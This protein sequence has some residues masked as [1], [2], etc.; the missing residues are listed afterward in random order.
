[1]QTICECGHKIEYERSDILNAHYVCCGD[2]T[3]SEDVAKLMGGFRADLVITDPP[4][5][6]N[7][8]GQGKKT[9]NKIENDN[10][11]RESFRA[12][13]LATFNCYKEAAKV[14]AP[15]YWQHLIATKKP[16]KF[17]R[18]FM[19]AIQVVHRGISRMQWN[20]LASI[21]EIRSSG[22][23]PS[24]AWAGVITDGNMSR[25]FMPLLRTRSTNFMEIV[26]NIRY[27][28]RNGILIKS[29]KTLKNIAKKWIK[30][31]RQFGK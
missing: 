20:P 22:I 23:K 31:V 18:L 16:R 6:V 14:S 11:S 21:S 9:S 27:W 7:Y 4:Y 26:H 3:K 29:S 30:E 24:Q 8:S 25:F 2:S 5:N 13:L 19:C 28:M 10:M 12:F 17:P 15:F 1:M